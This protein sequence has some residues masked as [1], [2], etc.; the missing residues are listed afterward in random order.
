LRADRHEHGSLCGIMWQRHQGCAGT[1]LLGQH[2]RA[3][4]G[5]MHEN[6]RGAVPMWRSAPTAA[7]GPAWNF[8][9]GDT[10]LGRCFEDAMAAKHLALSMRQVG[11][12]AAGAA[13]RLPEYLSQDKLRAPGSEHCTAVG[14]AN[15]GAGAEIHTA[16]QCWTLC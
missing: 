8:R 11:R 9:A 13:C 15:P 5:A 4:A 12:L 6:L 10:E 16:S 14:D 3:G 2:L 1:P 7:Q